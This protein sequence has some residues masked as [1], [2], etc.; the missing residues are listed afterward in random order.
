MK[1]IIRK[2][3]ACTAI[4]IPAVIAFSSDEAAIGKG[5][6][7]WIRAQAVRGQ[8][9]TPLS[10]AGVARR[11]TRRSYAAGA[12]SSPNCVQVADALGRMMTRCR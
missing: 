1:A 11:T 3:A 6:I 8:P 2:L 12:A 9:G 4:L 10:Y 5:E 7:S